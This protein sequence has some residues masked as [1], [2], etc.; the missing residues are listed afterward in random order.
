MRR[1][2]LLRD[3]VRDGVRF[4]VDEKYVHADELRVFD[5]LQYDLDDERILR[6]LRRA[7]RRD[8]LAFGAGEIVNLLGA[9]LW[10]AVDE[11]V[12]QGVGTMRV[13]LGNRLWARLR[14]VFQRSGDRRA[15]VPPLTP[16]QLR[17]VKDCVDRKLREAG[18]P[19]K[20]ARALSEQV[21]GRLVLDTVENEAIEGGS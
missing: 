10:I 19:E 15:E 14:R 9:M 1:T 6:R 7:P 3:V 2:V 5:A 13:S 17:V 16:S 8:P 11:S 4:A 18:L 12:R 21:V 20:Q